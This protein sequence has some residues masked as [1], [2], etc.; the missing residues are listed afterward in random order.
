MMVNVNV[1]KNS[2]LLILE[3]S[4]IHAKVNLNY[5]LYKYIYIKSNILYKV[6]NIIKLIKVVTLNV[7]YVQI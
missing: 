7:K 1:L 4:I 5:L 6:I 2:I 3:V